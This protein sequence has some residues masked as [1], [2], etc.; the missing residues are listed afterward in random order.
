[1]TQSHDPSRP[2]RVTLDTKSVKVLSKP[3]PEQDQPSSVFG[4]FNLGGYLGV[5]EDPIG[6]GEDV[7]IAIF[8]QGI[9]TGTPWTVTAS[10][11]EW[12]DTLAAPWSGAAL[13]LT[14]RV[15]FDQEDLQPVGVN[16][17]MRWGSPLPVA[18]MLTIG[19]L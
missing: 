18:V 3:R 1:M 14:H 16:F 9:I 7:A 15:Q 13:F 4:P 12:S 19:T 17:S 10:V 5:F 2:H 6:P 8:L 11:T